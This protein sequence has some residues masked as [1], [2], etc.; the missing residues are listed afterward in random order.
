LN[1]SWEIKTEVI[2]LNRSNRANYKE[3]T[4]KIYLNSGGGPAEDEFKK[5]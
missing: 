3:H 4:G 1:N 2:S 5:K